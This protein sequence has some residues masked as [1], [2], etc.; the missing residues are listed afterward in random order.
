MNPDYQALSN[1]VAEL[2]K[3]R[4]QRT[5]QQISFPLDVQSLNILMEYFMRITNL[6]TYEVVGASTHLVETYVGMQGKQSFQ[7]APNDIA[8]YT[9]NVSADTITLP[10]YI[11]TPT[12]TFSN[13][14]AVTVLSSGTPPNP[15][16]SVTTY[17]V[18]NSNG[19]TFKLSLTVGGAAINIT[20]TGTGQQYITFIQ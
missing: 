6:Y 5:Q 8:A 9:V 17:Y 12:T 20:D 16:D 19:T 13:D 7:V 3:W 1:R 10:S 4:A 15:L 2:E 14:R 18:I 11:S